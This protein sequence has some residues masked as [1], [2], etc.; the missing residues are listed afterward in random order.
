MISR[1]ELLKIYRVGVVTIACLAVLICGGLTTG[2]QI[3]VVAAPADNP[4]QVVVPVSDAAQLVESAPDED[5]EDGQM[6]TNHGRR[7]VSTA[8]FL[9][10]L[11]A[12]TNS[13]DSRLKPVEWTTTPLRTRAALDVRPTPAIAS[14]AQV[15]PTLGRQFT[16]VGAKPSGTS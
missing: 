10:G 3:Q 5:A 9:T 2:R 7:G 15:D 6:A 16:L 1:D 14:S 4:G 13:E 12:K 8:Y 11:M